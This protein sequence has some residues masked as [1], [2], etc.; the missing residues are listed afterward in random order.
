MGDM[1]FS[2][3]ALSVGDTLPKFD[4][5]TT[6]DVRFTNKDFIGVR[7]VLLVTG[8]I[9]C[10]MTASAM[11]DLKTL[12]AEFGDKVEFVMLTVRE[13]HPGENFPQPDTNE[14]KLEHARALK[15]HFDVPWT[16]AIDD[17]DG[18]LHK[19]LDG[20]PNDAYLI[21]A[22]GKVVFRSLWASDKKSLRQALESV[23]RGESPSKTQSTALMGPLVSSFPYI[24]E[25][26]KLAGPQARRDLILGAPPM[27]LMGAIASLFK[28][29]NKR[30]REP[31]SHG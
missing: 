31:V 25:T 10:P 22:G 18:A 12:H 3:S 20:K 19:A 5:P 8:S 17:V 21:D 13:A 9:T 4:L 16:V 15:E 1:R 2:K 29:K 7:P 6:S 26:M 27:A 24:S 14:A 30:Q 28:S 11:P 23:S